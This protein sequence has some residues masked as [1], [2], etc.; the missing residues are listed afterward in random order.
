MVIVFDFRLKLSVYNERSSQSA[1]IDTKCWGVPKWSRGLTL[2]QFIVGSNPTSLAIDA[3]SKDL[4][5]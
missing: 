2:N 1:I 5:L 4:L 3:Y